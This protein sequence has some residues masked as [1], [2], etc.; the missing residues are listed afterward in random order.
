MIPD[1]FTTNKDLKPFNKIGR[2]SCRE[3]V[4]PAF[5]PGQRDRGVYHMHEFA[6]NIMFLKDARKTEFSP[7]LDKQ[8][9]CKDMQVIC[10]I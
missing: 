7:S 3:R 8:T 6:A 10:Q 9:K 5:S 1:C 2:A 4:Y